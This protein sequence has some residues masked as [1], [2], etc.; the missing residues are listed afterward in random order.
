MLQPMTKT[1]SNLEQRLLLIKEN[2]NILAKVV[3]QQSEY[4]RHILT[5]LANPQKDIREK[6]DWNENLIDSLE[7]KIRSEVINAIVLYS[8][9]AV[10]SRR[11][12]AYI[13]STGYLERIGDLYLN[14]AEHALSIDT[15]TNI[16]NTTFEQIMDMFNE[17]HKM[18]ANAIIAF[19]LPDAELAREVIENDHKI[20]EVYRHILG[21]L[22]TSLQQQ[23]SSEAIHTALAVNSINYNIERIS[24]NATNIAEATIYNAEGTNVKHNHNYDA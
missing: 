4:V 15:N 16:Y 22:P 1:V 5:N 10:E 20:D 8:P 9:R 18:V 24:D 23:Y 17:A 7:V 19:S 14:I 2:F 13:D 12:F 6:I 3:T 11:L 21:I